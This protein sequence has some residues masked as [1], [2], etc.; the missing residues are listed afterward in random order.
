MGKPLLPITFVTMTSVAYPPPTPKS[1]MLKH[2]APGPR[3]GIPAL[4]NT[5]GYLGYETGNESP[6]LGIPL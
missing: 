6:N 1:S 2:V 5:D 3:A 4:T